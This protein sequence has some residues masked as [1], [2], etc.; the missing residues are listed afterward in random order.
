MGSSL[1]SL[2]PVL[3]SHPEAQA[4]DLHQIRKSNL[5]HIMTTAVQK[6]L[7]DSNAEYASGFQEGHLALPPAKSYAVGECS[8]Y[9]S[10]VETRSIRIETRGVLVKDGI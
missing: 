8:N 10:A 4:A 6:N 1:S 3:H 5:T 7:V 2:L 9:S